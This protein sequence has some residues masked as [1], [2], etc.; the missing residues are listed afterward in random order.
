M[1]WKNLKIAHKLNLI[2]AFFLL[3]FVLFGTLAIYR[4]GGIKKETSKLFTNHLPSV[5]K[6]AELER[7]WQQAIFYLRSFGYSKNEQFLYDGLTHLQ[8]TKN[9]LN[10][11][12][13][14]LNYDISLN[15]QFNTLAKELDSF[16]Q[17]VENAKQSINKEKNLKIRLDAYYKE[18]QEQLN[19]SIVSSNISVK[20]ALALKAEITDSYQLV[21]NSDFKNIIKNSKII[22]EKVIQTSRLSASLGNTKVSSLIKNYNTLTQEA[23]LI[24]EDSQH[25]TDDQM[26]NGILLTQLLSQVLFKKTELAIEN[27]NVN[28]SNSITF[29]IWGMIILTVVS[30]I[31]SKF[32]T[33]SFTRPIY[34]LVKFAKQQA[35]GELNNQFELNQ[36]DEIGQ[37][38]KSIE[39]S[40][41]KIK[42]MVIGLAN[43]AQKV[44]DMSSNF[45]QKANELNN[46][47]SSQASSSEELS[48]AMEEM[49][50]IINQSA[51][52]SQSIA[53]SNK[54]SSETLSNEIRHT[55]H[56][57]EIMDELISKSGYIKEIARQTN[58]LALNASIEAAKAGIHGRGF[59]VVA[60]GIRELAERASEISTEMNKISA[61]GKEYSSLAGNSLIRLQDES[62]QTTKYIQKMSDSFQEQQSEAN[63]ITN[64][65]AEFNTYTQ[66]LAMMSEIISSE[67]DSLRKESY[68]MRN[69]LE[70]F[71][72]DGVVKIKDE[73]E[74]KR[75]FKFKNSLKIKAKNSNASKV[76][77]LNNNLFESP[78]FSST[79][80]NINN[81]NTNNIEVK[82]QDVYTSYN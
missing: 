44:K 38:A 11:L 45:N 26:D 66:S 34:Q 63:Q 31:S 9:I 35:K 13:D 76:N 74:K 55:Q 81:H 43:A 17:I 69:M 67:S 82:N 54:Q 14:S 40:N 50:T 32:L 10:A 49:A 4:L 71:S 73:T 8:F 24:W 46:H 33:Q 16:S 61:E 29:L 23:L 56:A 39:T 80:N 52:E 62:C 15:S 64:A 36:K 2:F 47:A 28:A 41:E 27:N 65:V 79:K 68:E 30:I 60:N 78:T 18:I 58:I 72:V 51:L 6:T 75:K 48:A 53:R 5:K 12:A 1:R 7:N 22:D 37:L 25:L 57:M 3:V 20:N 70:F 19:T 59:G 42:E 21:L 77:D